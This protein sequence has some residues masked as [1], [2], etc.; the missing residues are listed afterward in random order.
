MSVLSFPYPPLSLTCI[1]IRRVDV[2]AF[3]P[4]LILACLI[5]NNASLFMLMIHLNKNYFVSLFDLLNLNRIS[6]SMLEGIFYSQV[7]NNVIVFSHQ[8]RVIIKWKAKIN[9]IT[10]PEY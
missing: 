2:N 6:W 10:V 5:L 4:S 8:Q 9:I 7:M 3:I 1:L